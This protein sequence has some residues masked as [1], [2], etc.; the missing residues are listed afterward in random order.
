MLWAEEFKLELGLTGL[1]AVGLL[2]RKRGC[3]GLQTKTW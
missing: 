1:R 2:V 3:Q